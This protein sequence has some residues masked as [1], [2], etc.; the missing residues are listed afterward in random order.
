MLSRSI[1][2][3][4]YSYRE[5][6]NFIYVYFLR[7]YCYKLL[8]SK[9]C[10]CNNLFAQRIATDIYHRGERWNVSPV[11]R[12]LKL[13]VTPP[14]CL[15]DPSKNDTDAVGWRSLLA[16]NASRVRRLMELFYR[17]LDFAGRSILYIRT[18]ES[19]TS[20][21]R[22]SVR[23]RGTERNGIP[24]YG[25]VTRDRSYETTGISREGRW[26]GLES[27]KGRRETRKGLLELFAHRCDGDGS[28]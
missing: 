19:R 1:Y 22:G 23:K 17:R 18:D 25:L 7:K 2:P 15:N 3:S 5:T 27:G 14:F 8:R 28:A 10:R 26:E 24:V 21:F 6:F 4:L 16:R 13:V 20:Y 9:Y 12:S 11:C